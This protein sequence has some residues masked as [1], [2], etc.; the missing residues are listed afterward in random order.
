MADTIKI[1]ALS[2]LGSGSL[3][4]NSVIPVVD[5]G[6]T[7]K[8]PISN[9]KLLLDDD[10]ASESELTSQISS[11]TSTISS[12]TT[13]NITEGS[14][15]Y[16]TDA[17]VK[18][19]MNADGVVSGSVV[20]SLP[21][22]VVSGSKQIENLGFITS[23]EGGG[24]SV[25]TGTVSSSVQIIEGL[26][27][28]QI[29]SGSP[30][31]ET[32]GYVLT[33]STAS[34][35]VAFATSAS[36]ASSSTLALTASYVLGGGGG[37]TDYISNITYA[38]TT[39]T[40]TGLGS[41][42]N[43]TI[44]LSSTGEF[45]TSANAASFVGIAEFNLYTGS[46]ETELNDIELNTSASWSQIV[47]KPEGLVSGSP[48]VVELLPSGLFSSSAQVELAAVDTTG[49]STDDVE[50]GFTNL[51]FS[52]SRV[53][54]I[55]NQRQVVSGSGGT[56]TIPNGTVSSS[57][58][59]EN[60]GF[61]T[62]T[63]VDNISA[64][65]ATDVT[66]LQDNAISLGVENFF[67]EKINIQGDLDVTGS[68]RIDNSGIGTNY[69][70]SGSGANLYDIPSSSIVGLENFLTPTQILA[71]NASASVSSDNGFVVVS[72]QG[73]TFTGSLFL[74]DNL[75]VSGTSIVGDV[76]ASNIT[77]SLFTGDG[78]GLFNIPQD[79]LQGGGGGNAT[80]LSSGSLTASLQPPLGFVFDGDVY[81]NDDVTV[82]GSLTAGT[83]GSPTLISDTNIN[84]SASNAVVINSSPLRIGS[85]T[86]TEINNFSLSEGDIWY[87][88]TLGDLFV[89]DGA[90]SQ[91][92][93]SVTQQTGLISGSQQLTDGAVSGEIPFVSV[94]NTLIYTSSLKLVSNELQVSKLLVN[95]D[96]TVDG[97][98]NLSGGGRTGSFDRVE[99]SELSIGAQYEFPTVDGT[100]NQILRTD[101]QGNVSFDSVP[102]N[103]FDGNEVSASTIKASTEIQ[104]SAYIGDT[105]LLNPS[106]PLPP[107]Q[108]GLIA[109]SASGELYFYSSSWKQ[110]SIVP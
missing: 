14:D 89:L 23:S 54:N 3:D 17:R 9:L 86:T 38:G 76:T 39:L 18:I 75:T 69:S 24:G 46:I 110:I 87:D 99:T 100:L 13:D 66:F 103:S 37:S 50:E 81:F 5:G 65:F 31:I 43:S 61:Y 56:A 62:D 8:L 85:F 77:A 80:K 51:Y 44:D 74:R 26:G 34:A 101:G 90:N 59:I 29:I 93:T 4:D 104:S 52:E 22:G 71:P 96:A 41:A 36:Y 53:V 20:T 102:S 64:S 73:S 45:L 94:T 92:L 97:N 70:F 30:Q 63:E 67:T 16:Y 58:Q 107:G 48:Q 88:T 95:G 2:T 105:L 109:V 7:Y 28:S 55:L 91:S 98:F 106:D 83:V 35:N 68:I 32:L 57:L 19:K 11:V 108:T 47:N 21:S 82:S 78:A 84:L 60:L 33:S 12:L 42:F 10:F 6:T 40:F 27:G 49:F 1:S 15:L 79:A 25:P 72:N